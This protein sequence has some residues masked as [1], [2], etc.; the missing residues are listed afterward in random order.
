MSWILLVGAALNLAGAAKFLIFEA[1]AANGESTLFKWF[2]AGAAT[3]F[4]CM[5]LFL[6]WHT[7]YVHPFLVFGAALKTWAFV[8]ALVLFARREISV[9]RLAD[10]GVT[11]GLVALGFWAYLAT[12]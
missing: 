7:G 8:I 6:F 11:N 2:T 3:V 10:F 12:T 9:R 4:G 1:H 5:Y